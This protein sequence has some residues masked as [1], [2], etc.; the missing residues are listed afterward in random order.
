MPSTIHGQIERITFH[1]EETGFSI[2]KVK[3]RGNRELVTAVGS[4]MAPAP[5]QVIKAT[6]EWENHQL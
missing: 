2:L 6:G 4:F 3:V 5:G 1:N